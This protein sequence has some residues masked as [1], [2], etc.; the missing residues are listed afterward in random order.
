MSL[1]LRR[2]VPKVLGAKVILDLHDPMPEL[3]MTIFGSQRDGRVVRWM[4]ILE[5]WSITFS[6]TVITVNRACKKLFAARAGRAEDIHVVMN[7]PDESIFRF[8]PVLDDCQRKPSAAQPFVL[9]YHGTL[10]ERNGLDLAVEAISKLRQSLPNLVLRVYGKR[11]PY[12]DEVM[13]FVSSAGLDGHVTCHG[14][15]GLEELSEAISECDVGVIPNKRSIFTEINTPTRI[16]EYLAKGKPVVAPRSG[17]IL[18]YFGDN[19]LV[20]F[21]LGNADQLAEKLS[22]VVN[23]PGQVSRVVQRGQDVYL[24]HT[25]SEEKARL[26]GLVSSL[27]RSNESTTAWAAQRR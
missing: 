21:E 23:N 18:E 3:M 11:T 26:L 25:W 17:G 22:W 7:S 4:T 19:A 12:L 14:H 1:C 8:V 2:I 9:M 20:Y 24:D 6:D 15:K 5:R 13:Q 10:V 27:L 16:F